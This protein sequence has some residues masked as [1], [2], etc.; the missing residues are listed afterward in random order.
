MNRQTPPPIREF[1]KLILNKPTIE[2]LQNGI[3][4]HYENGGEIDVNRIT[5]ALPRGEAESPIVGMASYIATMLS[6]GTSTLSGEQIANILEYNG[7]WL[8]T[9]VSTHY[10]TVSL[11]SINDNFQKVFPILV[12]IIFNPSF[13]ED[14][15]KMKLAQAASSLELDREKVSFLAEEALRKLSYGVE[16]PLARPQTPDSV[17]GISAKDMAKFHF[18]RLTLPDI[19]L[20]ISGRIDGEMLSTIKSTLSGVLSSGNNCFSPLCFPE[21]YIGSKEIYTKREGSLQSAIKMALPVPGRDNIDYVALRAAVIALG[22]YFGS[23]LMLNIREERGLTYGISSALIG[24]REK[25]FVRIATQTDSQSVELVK[26]LIHLEIEKMKDPKTY[27]N[28]EIHRL[29]RL[30]MSNLANIL[31]TPFS[32]MDFHQ[33]E[34]LA[35]T[36]SEYFQEQ[37]QYARNLSAKG[38]AEIAD[39]YF[40]T[41]KLLTSIAGAW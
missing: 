13:P 37:E 26:E 11:S 21:S 2:R 19:H 30:L 39:K 20:F 3:T 6:E 35:D 31:D 29:S 38:L 27:T 12:D 28:D 15:C 4:L 1:G 24:Y 36:P 7:A 32:R 14:I 22:G 17:L 5:I 23:R 8:G 34:L 41:N 9:S 16:N 33:T 25:G 10:T 18:S 40:D